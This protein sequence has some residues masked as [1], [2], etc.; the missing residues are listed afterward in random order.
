MD[1][2][3]LKAIFR[4]AAREAGY[5]RAE[6]EVVE[7]TLLKVRWFRT[8]TAILLDVPDYLEE[9]TP[10][11]AKA[12]AEHILAKIAG[13]GGPYPELVTRELTSEGF[14]LANRGRLLERLARDGVEDSGDVPAWAEYKALAEEQGV[15]IPSEV[16]VILAPPRYDGETVFPMMRV[17]LMPRTVA[18]SSR[19]VRL[20]WIEAAVVRIGIGPGVEGAPD[21]YVE[22]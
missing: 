3:R 22:L 2:P 9:L 20:A 16:R 17:A 5:E 18:R 8:S 21:R 4:K 1:A 14:A 10:K 13:D 7:E 6:A 11:A 15:A 19:A 12:L